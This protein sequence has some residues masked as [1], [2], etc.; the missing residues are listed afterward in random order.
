MTALTHRE[1]VA[2]VE[3]MCDYIT[4]GALQGIRLE[5]VDGEELTLRLPYRS[6]LVGNPNTGAI[7]G[8]ALT[9]LL[10]QALGIAGLCCDRV[11]NKMTATLDLRIDH[12]GVAPA[13]RDILASARVYR[14]TRRILFVEG[15]AY[16]DSRESPIAR[17]TGS[18][19]LRGEFSPQRCPPTDE[20]MQAP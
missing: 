15:I 17:A 16:C 4:H 20:G 9:V 13:G 1:K 6:S 5:A 3:E 7:H 2:L 10:D 14:A 8:G 18:W 12:L 19:V 11:G